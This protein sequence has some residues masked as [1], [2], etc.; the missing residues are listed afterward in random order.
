MTSST[1][2]KKYWWLG[3]ILALAGIVFGAGGALCVTKDS[4]SRHDKAIDNLTE[5]AAQGQVSQGRLDERLKSIDSRLE[6]IERLL[7]V[8]IQGKP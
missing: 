7:T 2:G 4:L 1:N 6:G 3:T 8:R 5:K